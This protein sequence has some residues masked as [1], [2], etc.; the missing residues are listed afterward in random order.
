MPPRVVVFLLISSTVDFF[1]GRLWL[2]IDY[3]LLVLSPGQHFQRGC[4]I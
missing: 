1:E 4:H 3:L 2:S